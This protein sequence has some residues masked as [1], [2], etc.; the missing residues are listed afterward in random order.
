MKNN[1]FIKYKYMKKIKVSL[2]E[3]PIEYYSTMGK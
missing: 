1:K 3:R 2:E